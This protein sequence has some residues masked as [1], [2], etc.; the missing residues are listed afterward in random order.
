M[1]YINILFNQLSSITNY[2]N[3]KSIDRINGLEIEV[4]CLVHSTLH[5]PD[6]IC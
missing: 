3:K 1:Q 2:S 5:S 6:V 4:M